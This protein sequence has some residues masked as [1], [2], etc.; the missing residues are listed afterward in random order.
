MK[1]KRLARQFNLAVRTIEMNTKDLSDTETLRPPPGGG[2]PLNWILGHV[3]YG[4]NRMLQMIGAP[5]VGGGA[6]EE[7][8]GRGTAP[9]PSHRALPLAKLL[10]LYRSTQEPILRFLEQADEAA[11]DRPIETQ[12][13]ILGST[14]GDALCALIW[15]EGYHAGQIGTLRRF[16]GKPGA[17][18]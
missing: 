6:L 2:N 3:V 7:L 14:V 1:E 5:E 12:S 10:A 4:R 17:I 11:L 16:A 8:Y 13:E 9:P 15:H 18:P